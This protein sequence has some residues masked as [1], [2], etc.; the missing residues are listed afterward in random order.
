[1]LKH[2]TLSSSDF[3]QFPHQT[4]LSSPAGIFSYLCST[5]SD[6]PRCGLFWGLW[7]PGTPRH[8]HF[9]DPHLSLLLGCPS[10]GQT[11]LCAP[12]TS[13]LSILGKAATTQQ[14]VLHASC[15]FPTPFGWA[16]QQT[17]ATWKW[18]NLPKDCSQ[19]CTPAATREHESFL[20]FYLK[21]F[22]WVKD[23]YLGQRV[24]EKASQSVS[25][26]VTK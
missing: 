24:K 1:M 14:D 18:Q 25:N 8:H 7:V 16:P 10:R 15:R 3:S 2:H 20:H 21:T 11:L 19:I 5:Y 9:R 6:K 26:Q 4:S 23:G 13:N 22:W 17:W 12:F